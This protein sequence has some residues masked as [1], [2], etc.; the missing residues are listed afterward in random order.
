MSNLMRTGRIALY[1]ARLMVLSS[2]FVLL[3]ALAYVFM[4]GVMRPVREFAADFGLGIVPAVF[5][6]FISDTIYCNIALLL[7]VF[8][9]CDIPLK[10]GAQNFLLQ[11]GRG[12]TR[13]G[14]GHVLALF[15]AGATFVLVQLLFTVLTA[16]P[17]LM[18]GDWGKAWGSFASSQASELGY[19]S[20]LAI[21]GDVLRIYE[22]WQAVGLS[23]L[24]FLLAG[25]VYAVVEYILN[26]LT[27]SRLGTAA[28]SIWSLLWIFLAN[29]PFAWAEKLLTKAPQNW[30]DLSRLTPGGAL[31]QAGVLAVAVLVL[32]A[33][34]VFLVKRRKI[35]MVR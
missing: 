9:F 22:P 34:A 35:E 15:F 24:L 12:L 8:L 31:R 30:L 20:S 13:S 10:N 11:R 2:R 32:A 4:D 1:D 14:A 7:L 21:S 25:C 17:G 29:L 33:V 6:F 3:S 18:F 27:R 26:G 16:L 5:P 28:L 19:A 23:A